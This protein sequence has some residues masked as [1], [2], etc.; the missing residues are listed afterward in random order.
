MEPNPPPL[1]ILLMD[2]EPHQTLIR[3]ARERLAQAGHQVDYVE[4]IEA[5]IEAYYRKFYDL[6]ILDIDMSH[7]ALRLIVAIGGDDHLGGGLV[8]EDLLQCLLNSGAELKLRLNEDNHPKGGEIGT[9]SAVEQRSAESQGT[10]GGEIGG[11]PL[12]ELPRHSAEQ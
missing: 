12:Q 1:Q 8:G 4:T 2:D 9:G 7:L 6:F 11:C 10:V 5:A 3:D